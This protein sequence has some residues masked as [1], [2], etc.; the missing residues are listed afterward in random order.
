[1][2][3]LHL[4][5]ASTSVYRYIVHVDASTDP[6]ITEDEVFLNLYLD[7]HCSDGKGHA[8]YHFLSVRQLSSETAQGLF[9]C[10]VGV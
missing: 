6:G 9:N 7:Y 8:R 4:Q 1:M 3:L 2:Y 5:S 10:L